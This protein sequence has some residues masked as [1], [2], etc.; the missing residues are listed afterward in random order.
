MNIAP[1][2]QVAKRNP[3]RYTTA[4]LLTP[5]SLLERRLKYCRNFIGG[6]RVR[7]PDAGQ[8]LSKALEV[9]HGRYT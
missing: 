6:P 9:C 4:E 2:R 7:P 1:S 3:S 5:A 8:E